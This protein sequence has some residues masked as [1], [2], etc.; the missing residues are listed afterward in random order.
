M[1]IFLKGVTHDFSEKILNFFWISFSLKKN[2]DKMFNNVLNR[3][4]KAF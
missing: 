3:E 2:L 1:S 4:K